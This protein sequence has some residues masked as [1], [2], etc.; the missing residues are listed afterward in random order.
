[1]TCIRKVQS[2]SLRL[3]LARKGYLIF[4]SIYVAFH[5]ISSEYAFKNVY[6][7]IF[8]LCFDS[9][10]KSSSRIFFRRLMSSLRSWE[11]AK[12]FCFQL[13]I[14]H[15][16]IISFRDFQGARGSV[17]VWTIIL[18][19]IRTISSQTTFWKR[20][21]VLA[22]FKML[23]VPF[24]LSA[25]LRLQSGKLMPFGFSSFIY[26]SELILFISCI[27]FWSTIGL[28]LVILQFSMCTLS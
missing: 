24:E 27:L 20:W 28:I 11:F 17:R 26:I 21:D 22:L 13:I 7:F 23:P 14:K 10:V 19:K 4:C 18:N 5:Q 16:Q 8:I 12:I 1:M 9:S 6:Q 3:F 25:F 15:H 2:C